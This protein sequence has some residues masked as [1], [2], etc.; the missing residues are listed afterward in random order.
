MH[1]MSTPSGKKSW[2]TRRERVSVLA[3]LALRKET[4]SRL[5]VQ[6]RNDNPEEDGDPL[7]QEAAARLVGV[8]VRQWQRWEAGDSVPYP[9]N[10]G[11]IADTFSFDVGQF[12]ES[13]IAEKAETPNPFPASNEDQELRERLERVEAKLD[14]VLRALT[15]QAADGTLGAEG[16]LRR[17]AEGS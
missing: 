13:E 17:R 3:A 14:R 16:E 9:R 7:S 2:Q 5:L 12:Y 15:E 6:I 11:I 8:S 1:V 4:V 10:L